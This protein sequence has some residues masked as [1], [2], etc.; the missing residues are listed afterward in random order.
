VERRANAMERSFVLDN[1]PR[2]NIASCQQ[3]I[4][5][6]II[7]RFA[8]GTFPGVGMFAL[9]VSTGRRTAASKSTAPRHHKATLE[10]ISPTAT[11]ANARGIEA[12][13]FQT[14]F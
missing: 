7:V 3:I 10:A 6:Q 1:A 2:P 12:T 13:S 5:C 11:I 4:V 8:F 9:T 14:K